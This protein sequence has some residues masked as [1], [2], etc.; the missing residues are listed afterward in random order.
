MRRA[1]LVLLVLMAGLHLRA[2]ARAAARGEERRRPGPAR[3]LPCLVMETRG[4]AAD[5]QRQG[6]D[7]AAGGRRMGPLRPPGRR[8]FHRPA[9]AHRADRRQGA[10]SARAHPRL[11]AERRLSR[12]HRPGQRALVGRLHLL[13]HRQ[14]GRA[15]RSVL[16]G[17]RATRS[18]SSAW[19]SARAGR[20]RPSSRTGRPSGRPRSATLYARHARAAAPPS[21]T[22][23]AAPPIAIS[24]S[25]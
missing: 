4:A 13:G 22:S 15:A 3:P 16:P 19:S 25:R 6:L 20:V 24:W 2:S 23:T 17:L 14:R 21:T 1:V 11:L 7:G 5:G 8:L 18:M 10:R 9:A 12:A